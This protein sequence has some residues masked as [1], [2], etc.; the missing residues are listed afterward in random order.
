ME[1][2][3]LPPQFEALFKLVSK[4]TSVA[5]DPVTTKTFP[6][7]WTSRMRISCLV[8]EGYPRSNYRHLSEGCMQWRG[9]MS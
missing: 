1:T 7:S 3:S 8:D 6:V 2:T 5:T 9:S 4:V